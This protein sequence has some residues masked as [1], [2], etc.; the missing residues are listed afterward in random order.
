MVEIDDEV[1]FADEVGVGGVVGV[2]V[3]VGG[4]VGVVVEIVLGV[5]VVVE[6]GVEIDSK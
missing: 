3:E 5:V 2:V 1:G 4:V 6:V